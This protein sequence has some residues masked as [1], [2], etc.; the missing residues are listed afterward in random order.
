MARQGLILERVDVMLH[1][2]GDAEGA[3]R[4]LHTLYK[5]TQDDVG[6]NRRIADALYAADRMDDASNMYG[7]LVQVGRQAKRNKALA[8]D[9]TR[10]ARISLAG[11]EPDGAKDQLLEA[12]RIDTTNVET[13]MVLG[14]VH[15]QEADWRD[16][17]KIYRTMLLQNAD[18]SGLLRRGDIYV[19]LARAHVALDEKP[20]ARAMLRRGLEE[21][22][23]HPELTGQLAALED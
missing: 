1:R 15:E 10:L 20:K 17:L 6:I 23:E 12:Y 2:M 22:T 11:S 19:N 3:L 8:H 18:Q 14:S 13:L 9:L 4:V 5:E 16:A 21:D 7:W